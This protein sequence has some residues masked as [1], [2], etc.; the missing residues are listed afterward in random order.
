[1]A[2]HAVEIILPKYD[3]MRYDHIWGLDVA[4]QNLWVP[5]FN[6]HIHCTVYFGFVHGRKCFFIE[7]HSSDNFFNRDTYY[8]F[9]DEHMRYAFFSKAA[10]E[11]MYHS[12]KR[13]EIIHTHDWQTALVPPLMTQI[14]DGENGGVMMNEFPSKYMDVMREASHSECPPMN[15]TEYL[16]HLFASGVTEASLPAVQPLFHKLIWER[17]KPGDGPEKLARTISA[18]RDENHRPHGGRLD[19]QHVV[20]A[21]LQKRAEADGSDQLAFLHE[22]DRARGADIRAPLP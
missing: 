4:Y 22:G 20:G 2:G 9:P 16:E 8:G 3:C 10:L 13:P 7:P 15:A 17:M 18:I 5:W 1:M 21:R 11:F 12:G 19:E 6:Y 14:A